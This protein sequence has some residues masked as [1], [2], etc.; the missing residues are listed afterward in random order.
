MEF[1]L[2]AKSLK[3]FA[4]IIGVFWAA[5][6]LDRSACLANSI[7]DNSGNI[8]GIKIAAGYPMIPAPS[9]GA[10]GAVVPPAGSSDTLSNPVTPVIMPDNLE[11]PIKN[12]NPEKPNS[13]AASAET[14]RKKAEAVIEYD[15]SLAPVANQPGLSV[16]KALNE[17]LINSPRAAAVRAQFAIARANYAYATQGPNPIMFMDRGLVA[18]QTMRIGPTLTIEP[19]WKLLFRLLA[20]KRLVEQTK[21]DL[22][23]AL[24]ALRIDV[25]K[26]YV[27]VVVAQ[28]TLKTLNELYDLS[29]K[30]STVASKRHHAGDVPKLDL[31]KAKLANS[32]NQVEL[33][34]GQ[35][36]VVR[37]YQQLNVIMGK[38]VDD[39]I[40]VPGLPGFIGKSA[41]YHLT[42]E[43]SD[44][45]PD[46]DLAIPPAQHFIDLAFENRLELK[47][48]NAQLRVNN[49][50]LRTAYG[51]I[52]PNA[53]LTF[54]K[55]SASNPPVGPK[56]NATFFTLNAEMPFS[57]WHQ[58]DIF[59]Y[60]ATD[61]QLHYQIGA[62]R[63]Q[64]TAEVT[65]AYQNLV[66]QREK[67][68]SY[69]DHI[70]ADSYEV[71]RLARRSYEVGQSDITSTLQAQQANVQ[72]RSQYLDA[73]MSYASAF[74]DLEMSSGLPLQ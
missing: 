3:F 9:P 16:V 70:L 36:R 26:A 20:T 47:S 41:E 7:Y 37:S 48:L 17:A 55:S 57:N 19:P 23:T 61:K 2:K 62:V 60:K 73:V 49:A 22:L 5:A 46:F 34:V 56:L 21:I 28:E 67:I 31:L 64:V 33:G 1:F 8:S 32:Q 69:Q 30:L 13:Q 38:G 72:I 51:N 27:E 52:I 45:M 29:S 65:S 42:A 59:T 15:V 39:P 40:N 68:Q 35:K 12:I 14:D 50:N 66:A 74:A 6:F 63:N 54:G 4:P 58:G 53:T 44:I 43:K 11:S 24:W 18:E 25:R 10:P 71:A